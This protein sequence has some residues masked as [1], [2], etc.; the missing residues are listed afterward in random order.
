MLNYRRVYKYNLSLDLPIKNC[1][2]PVGYAK[3][4]QCTFWFSHQ[5]SWEYLG[6]H[7][8]TSHQ[9]S[10]PQNLDRKVLK[11]RRNDPNML[12]HTSSNS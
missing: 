7:P 4:P 6:V 2:C 1:N 3:L 8:T 10:N 11:I 12:N 9:S 5:N